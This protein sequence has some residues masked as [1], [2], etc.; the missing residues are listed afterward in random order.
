MLLGD[1]KTAVLGGGQGRRSYGK[2][3][4]MDVVVGGAQWG[5]VVIDGVE[6][7]DGQACGQ[8]GGM[9]TLQ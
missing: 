5:D 7:P 4:A 2:E 8:R 9:C 6:N 3:V 1:A